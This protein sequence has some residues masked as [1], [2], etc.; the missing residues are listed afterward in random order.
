VFVAIT[1]FEG[2]PDV[3]NGLDRMGR[4]AFYDGTQQSLQ[5]WTAIPRSQPGD[6]DTYLRGQADT[7]S[8]LKE[9]ATAGLPGR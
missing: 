9:K 1:G 4:V 2:V 7:G 3:I 8:K 5:P 6:P